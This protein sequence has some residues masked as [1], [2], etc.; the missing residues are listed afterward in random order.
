MCKIVAYKHSSHPSI[1][2]MDGHELHMVAYEL[3]MWVSALQV[4]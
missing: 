3:V 1:K 4:S 2:K